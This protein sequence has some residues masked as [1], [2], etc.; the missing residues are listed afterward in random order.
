MINGTRSLFWVKQLSRSLLYYAV[1]LIG[2]LDLFGARTND[3][4]GWI[5]LPGIVWGSAGTNGVRAGIWTTG[6]ASNTIATVW[7]VSGTNVSWP[8]FRPPGTKFYKVE[9]YDSAG[10]YIA[11]LRGKKVYGDLPETILPPEPQ[12]GERGRGL[13]GITSANDRASLRDRLFG[14]LATL[15][16]FTVQNVYPIEKE[17]NYKLTIGATIYSFIPDFRRVQIPATNQSL[18]RF[19][20]PCVTR[21]IH[22]S[23][24][25]KL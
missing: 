20:L 3:I 4:P 23:P 18:L 17:G 7:V 8:Y 16:S 12:R 14:P 25:P 22:L 19:D 24:R 9:L 1:I 6:E 13:F 2:S 5:V 21:T 15:G 11:P 10:A